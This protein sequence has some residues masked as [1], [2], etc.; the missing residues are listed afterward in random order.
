MPY[1]P[2]GR[3]R[4]DPK[5]G[6]WSACD[7]CG[8]L[9]SQADLT[10]QYDF[11]GGSTPQRLNL[12]VCRRTCLDELNYSNMLL[13][14]PPDPPPQGVIRPEAFAVD[15]TNW[16]TTE[17]GD[18]LDTQSG[19][20]LITSIPDPGQ[21]A[22]TAVIYTSLTASGVTLTVAY[23]DL[24]IGDPT[25]TGHSVLATITGSSARTNVFSSLTVSLNHVATNADTLTVSTASAA[26][27]S[28]NYVAIY[29]ATTGGNL[30]TSGRCSVSTDPTFVA[31]PI[32]VANGA[33]VQFNALG[34]SIDLN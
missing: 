13:I 9:Y 17:D 21:T 34:L 18:I 27:T 4:V 15:E 30:I 7:R 22:N 6:P 8:F 24:F 29:D 10:W 11:Q 20:D 2:H 33:I 5:L 32:M 12:L 14:I 3:A 19:L 25:T 1:R 28:V 23:L 31:N 26:A 16:L